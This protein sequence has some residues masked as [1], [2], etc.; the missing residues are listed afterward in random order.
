LSSQPARLQLAIP[1]MASTN[2][3]HVREIAVAEQ[4]PKRYILN[5]SVHHEI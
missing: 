4:N 3:P 5:A 1:V 2:L